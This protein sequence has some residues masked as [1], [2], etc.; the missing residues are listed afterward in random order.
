M[1]DTMSVPPAVPN[2][3]PP[4]SNVVKE[5]WL[6]KRGTQCISITFHIIYC[7]FKYVYKCQKLF[8]ILICCNILVFITI[9][10]IFELFNLKAIEVVILFSLIV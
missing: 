2:L 4:T 9:N 3:T 10:T 7:L 5:G 8:I 1:N 6:Q